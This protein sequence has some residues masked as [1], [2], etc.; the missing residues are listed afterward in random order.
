ME[1]PR[2]GDLQRPGHRC[3]G[4]GPHRP[5]HSGRRSTQYGRL[6]HLSHVTMDNNQ[7]VGTIA[8]GGAIA[9]VFGA[10]LEVTDSTFT[11]NRA[12]GT[13]FGSA[14]AILPR[15]RIGSSARRQHFRG[16]PATASLG[17]RSYHQ[18][19]QRRGRASRIQLAASRRCCI[20]RSRA[21]L[22]AVAMGPT[23]G[24]ARRA[25]TPALA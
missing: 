13:M 12:A 25:V 4:G 22:H 10:N 20:P 14:G 15:G 18:P 21:T 9:N 6:C 24:P 1:P 3:H 23:A 7:A 19:R 8:Q 2:L 17:A 5:R 11:E 16:Q